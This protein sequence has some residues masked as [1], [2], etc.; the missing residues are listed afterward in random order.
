MFYLAKGVV[1]LDS[2]GPPTWSYTLTH[3]DGCV[4][5]WFYEGAGITGANVTGEAAAGWTVEYTPTLVTFSNSISLTSGSVSGFE[6]TGMV[7]GTGS[8]LVCRNS[9]DIEGAL[10]VELLPFLLNSPCYKTFRIHST[11]KHGYHIS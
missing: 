3:Q 2:A 6:I 9:G 1:A 10:P 7:G 8:W 4:Y 5:N 11:L